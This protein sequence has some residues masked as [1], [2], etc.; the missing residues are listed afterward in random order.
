MASREENSYWHEWHL[1]SLS[2]DTAHKNKAPFYGTASRWERKAIDILF[3]TVGNSYGI[4][5][6]TAP[7]ADLTA[8]SP[9]FQK[10][11]LAAYQLKE[12][13]VIKGIIKE[14]VLS[15][16]P[17][18]YRYFAT[19]RGAQGSG[20]NG[21]GSSFF[22]EAGALW[23]AIGEA[24]DRYSLIHFAPRRFLDA[25]YERVSRRALD[26][27]SLAGISEERR[28]LGHAKHSLLFDKKT[29]FRWV[30][31]YSLTREEQ[32]WVPL[33]L[34]T[35]YNW[36]KDREPYLRLPISTGSAAGGT[37]EQA[38]YRGVLEVIERDA[39]MITW[40]KR[41]SP[42]RLDLQSLES[43]RIRKINEYFERY[44]LELN[45]LALPT[46][47]PCH[48]ILATVIDGRTGFAHLTVGLRASLNLEEAIIVAV[49]EALGARF[50]TRDHLSAMARDMPEITDVDK[51]DRLQRVALW[52]SQPEFKDLISFLWAGEVKSASEVKNF[53]EPPTDA[54]RLNFLINH[55]KREGIEVAYVKNIPY[56]IAGKVPFECAYVII[57][58]FQPMH[59]QESLPY[60]SGKRLETVPQKLN[61]R[62]DDSINTIPHP[63]P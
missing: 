52:A 38:L 1:P 54:E 59:L 26:I 62:V 11:L 40:L 13:G 44:R 30:K 58:E 60:F 35:F 48:V 17:K 36:P 10:A 34:V 32:I 3:A 24:I 46:D 9:D 53:F 37:L 2:A 4:K 41:L 6:S 8:H 16:E 45:V 18:M 19:V 27:F 23:A 12:A 14:R 61:L 22:S 51:I 47:V 25:P 42:P 56:A 43:P 50:Y 31:G 5:I 39:F 28:K 20:Q 33:Q 55:F 21:I 7:L 15:D 49:Q 29:M 63:F 57:P